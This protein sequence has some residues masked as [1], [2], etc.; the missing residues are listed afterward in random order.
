MEKI[1]FGSFTKE[2]FFVFMEN[3]K[4]LFARM[5]NANVHHQ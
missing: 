2:D 5:L 3:G 4:V 1:L